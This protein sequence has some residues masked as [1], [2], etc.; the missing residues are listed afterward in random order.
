VTF[1][2][3][4]LAVKLKLF[5]EAVM[6]E[7]ILLTL[8]ARQLELIAKPPRGTKSALNVPPLCTPIAITDAFP[9]MLAVLVSRTP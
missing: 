4:E 5:A 9:A 3:L 7:V 2:S 6:T 1:V 8:A